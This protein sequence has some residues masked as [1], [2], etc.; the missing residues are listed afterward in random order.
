MINLLGCVL[1]LVGMRCQIPLTVFLGRD[2]LKWFII[3]EHGKNDVADFM[4]NSSDSH[5]FLLAFA[6]VGIIAVDN[7]IYWCF[8]PF[9]HLKVIE[10][11]HMQD[12]PGKT[13]SPLGH[14]DFVT[15]ELA[16]LLHGRIQTE[17]SIKLLWGRKQVKEAHFSDQDDCAEKTDTTQGLEKEDTVIN[18]RPFQLINSLMQVLKLLS[19]SPGIPGRL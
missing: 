14:V 13:G 3:P 17:V 5:V 4:H 10:G 9:I 16:G 11:H 2:D 7:W 12:A 19:R 6:F 15:I 8:C 18:R 1:Y